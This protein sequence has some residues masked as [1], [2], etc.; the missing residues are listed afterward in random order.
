MDVAGDREEHGSLWSEGPDQR[1]VDIRLQIRLSSLAACPPA[2]WS[3]FW[4]G[5]A[6]GEF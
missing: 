5:A 3:S 6:G 1:N 4:G 2:L